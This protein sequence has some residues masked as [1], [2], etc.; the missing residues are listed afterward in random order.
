MFVL[1]ISKIEWTRRRLIVSKHNR[2]A[3][4]SAKRVFFLLSSF[5]GGKVSE[6]NNHQIFE[7]QSSQV[8]NECSKAWALD[9][10]S[11]FHLRFVANVVVVVVV[12]W[13]SVLAKLNFRFAFVIFGL[14]G[15]PPPDQTKP[16]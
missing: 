7:I 10:E 15:P 12:V 13:C 11:T 6:I 2:F 4:H 1:A 3:V 9:P 14:M 8:L 16:D 5:F